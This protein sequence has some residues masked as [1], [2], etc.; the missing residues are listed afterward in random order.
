MIS[1]TKYN[2]GNYALYSEEYIQK[3]LNRQADGSLF[4]YSEDTPTTYTAE[5]GVKVFELLEKGIPLHHIVLQTRLL[6]Q[7]VTRIKA[8]Y[9]DM[10]RS[11]TVP[12]AILD[13]M[14]QLRMRL[15]GPFPLRSATDMLSVMMIAAEDRTCFQ[16]K[17]ASCAELCVSC[18][19]GRFTP[20]PSD[21]AKTPTTNAN[22]SKTVAN[23]S[24][25]SASDHANGS[26]LASPLPSSQNDRQP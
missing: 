18:L 5:D 21:E 2:E 23:G 25:P 4:K 22:G 20:S 6:P 8:D 15:T 11:I 17:T 16:C 13:Q 24:S 9:N 3:L 1:A 10:I 19:R 26:S 12:S 14:D 7:V